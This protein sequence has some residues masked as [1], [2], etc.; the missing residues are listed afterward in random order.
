MLNYC[1]TSFLARAWD[2]SVVDCLFC[3]VLLAFEYSSVFCRHL[4]VAVLRM[5]LSRNGS[6]IGVTA[7]ELTLLLVKGL[8]IPDCTLMLD[9]TLNNPR[10]DDIDSM[11]DLRRFCTFPPELD[12]LALKISSYSLMYC[13][14][15]GY[16]FTYFC[17]WH[18]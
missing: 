4:G 15:C 1:S 17:F 10:D 3:V 7:R 18:S 5:L 13:L 12:R 8:S 9:L 2:S 11:E 14:Y 6:D 16:G